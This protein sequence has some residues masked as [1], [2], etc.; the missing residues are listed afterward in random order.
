MEAITIR[1][2]KLA[3]DVGNF[4]ASI[5]DRYGIRYRPWFYQ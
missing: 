3:G 4:Y 5:F 1:G 2:G